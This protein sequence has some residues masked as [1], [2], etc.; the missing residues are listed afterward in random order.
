MGGIPTFYSGVYEPELFLKY[1]YKIDFEYFTF[2][3]VSF[4]ESLIIGEQK[5]VLRMF[6]LNYIFLENCW[7]PFIDYFEFSIL[8][9][10]LN[11]I[12]VLQTLKINR[13][14]KVKKMST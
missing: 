9:K 4:I 2:L 8:K 7:S 11:L 14:K 5:L 3:V 13:V 12:F 10:Y 1:H 6:Y